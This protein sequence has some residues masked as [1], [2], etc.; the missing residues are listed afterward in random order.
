MQASP[1]SLEGRIQ[2]I[3]S[4]VEKLT[5]KTRHSQ[6]IP[7]SADEITTEIASIRADIEAHPTMQPADKEVLL[8]RVHE[9]EKKVNINHAKVEMDAA[10]PSKPAAKTGTLKV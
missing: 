4:T 8:G 2:A 7:D 9:V 6:A 5:D 10:L 3:E 1:N